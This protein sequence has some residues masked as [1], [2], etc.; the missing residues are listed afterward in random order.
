M[1]EIRDIISDT[2]QDRE[3]TFGDDCVA[4]RTST[5]FKAEIIDIKDGIYTI[6]FT[7]DDTIVNTS[8]ENLIIYFPCECDNNGFLNEEMFD[9]QISNY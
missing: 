1:S 3:V 9:E 8:G 4:L 7:D 5:Y 6:R 2:L